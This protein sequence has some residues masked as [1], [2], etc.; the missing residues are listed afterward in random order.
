[1]GRLEVHLGDERDCRDMDL[2]CDNRPLHVFVFWIFGLLCLDG[3][4]RGAR[5]SSTLPLRIF[6]D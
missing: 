2:T 3:W 1:M 4:A 6:H 5:T